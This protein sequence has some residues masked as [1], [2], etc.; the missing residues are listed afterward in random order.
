MTADD[1]ARQYIEIG[2]SPYKELV[3]VIQAAMDYASGKSSSALLGFNVILDPTLQPTEM[4]VTSI[5]D[6]HADGSIIA[7]VNNLH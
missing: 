7:S 1:F 3:E 5:V 2:G 4:A 6:G